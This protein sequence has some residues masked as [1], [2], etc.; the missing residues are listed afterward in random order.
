[1]S[2]LLAACASEGGGFECA[3]DDAC[4]A[5]GI[6]G[7]C[8]P[9]NYCS[10]P[11]PGCDSAQRYAEHAPAGFAEECVPT[12]VASSG[13]TQSEAP[14]CIDVELGSELGS[15]DVRTLAGR[16]DD[17]SPSC[18]SDTGQDV[19]YW[20]TASVPGEYEFTATGAV[21]T[22]VTIQLLDACDSE[23]RCDEGLGAVWSASLRHSF[24]QGESVIIVVDGDNGDDGMYELTV[25]LVTE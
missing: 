4:V 17:F 15:V 16:G 23:L 9:N 24:A 8:Q 22:D 19:A 1:M 25:T 3:S 12:D 10:F 13:T 20:W 21:F 6:E 18:V 2:G 5:G 7:I 14:G 11:D